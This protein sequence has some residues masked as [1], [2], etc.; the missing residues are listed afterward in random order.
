[1]A[2]IPE[3]R[4]RPNDAFFAIYITQD[5]TITGIDPFENTLV[6]MDPKSKPEGACKTVE[7]TPYVEN[8]HCVWVDFG[9][10]PVCVRG[11]H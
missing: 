6:D 11:A 8:P 9:G 1:M 4:A 7:L 3:V 5:G 2:S 10:I